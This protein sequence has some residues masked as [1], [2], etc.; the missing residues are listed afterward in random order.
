MSTTSTPSDRAS[1]ARFR[2]R[3]NARATTPCVRGETGTTSTGPSSATSSTLVATTSESSGSCRECLD[4]TDRVGA[5]PALA[6]L[7]VRRV[8]EDPERVDASPSEA[9]ATRLGDGRVPLS[10]GHERLGSSL[11][12]E[13]L[14]R[15]C[16]GASTTGRSSG[17]PGDSIRRAQEARV[18]AGPQGGAAAADRGRSAAR[19][20]LHGRVAD[21]GHGPERPR[22][23]T[24]RAMEAEESPPV[25]GDEERLE[26]RSFAG[27]G[28]ALVEGDGTRDDERAIALLPEPP[29]DVDVLEVREVERLEP[30]DLGQRGT[31]DEAAAGARPEDLD[32][33]RED[34][35]ASRPASLSAGIPISSTSMPRLLTTDGFGG[36]PDV[37]HEAGDVGRGVPRG[38]EHRPDEVLGH[39]EVGVG[40]HDPRAVSERRSPATLRRRS[41]R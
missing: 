31:A 26:P 10:A 33:L 4:E 24:R 23:E 2:S 29:A 16:R 21:L 17:M 37:R 30:A 13:S 7:Q 6:R 40:E 3:H 20:R 34:G 41:P 39:G 8:D 19:Q 9:S 14:V 35:S 25:A 12:A 15:V 11:A 22:R 32:R 5:D 18:A 28:G 1:E 38:L 36:V 27:R